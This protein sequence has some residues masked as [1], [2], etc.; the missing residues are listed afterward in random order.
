MGP[1]FRVIEI[2]HFCCF[3]PVWGQKCCDFTPGGCAVPTRLSGRSAHPP[4]AKTP[5]VPRPFGAARWPS[6]G[7][8]PTG[9]GAFAKGTY[10]GGYGASYHLPDWASSW[11]ARAREQRRRARPGAW[12]EGRRTHHDRQGHG[13]PGSAHLLPLPRL[14]VLPGHGRAGADPARHD[15]GAGPARSTGPVTAETPPDRDLLDRAAPLE[16]IPHC[17][18]SGGELVERPGPKAAYAS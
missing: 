10:F 8:P 9:G 18:N 16:P 3:R 14:A 4:Q 6:D 12:A 1:A 17:V 2:A 13:L 5:P 15:G 7:L 11:P